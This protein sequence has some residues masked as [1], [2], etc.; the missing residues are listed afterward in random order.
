[1]LKKIFTWWDGATI[2]TLLFSR[3][4]GTRVGADAL[5]NVYFE[6]GVTT[7]GRKRMMAS[8]SEPTDARRIFPGWDEPAFKATFDLSVTVPQKFL[9]VSNMPVAREAPGRGGVKRVSFE[10]TPRMST[11]CAFMSSRPSSNTAN[12]PIGPAPIMTTSVLI[13]SVM[14]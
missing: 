10:R 3:R 7:D 8:H 13:G 6:G 14:S 1:M 9:T 12:K 4:N 5:G 11:R 2:G